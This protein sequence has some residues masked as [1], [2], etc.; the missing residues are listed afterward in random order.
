MRLSLLSALLI[1]GLWP[2]AGPAIAQLRQA[3][4][5][6]HGPTTVRDARGVA[7][8]LRQPPARIVSLAPAVTEI[9]FAVGAGPNVVGVTTYCDYPPQARRIAKVGD[10]NV[11]TEKVL[12][13]KPDLIIGDVEANRKSIAALERLA[14][15]RG[16]IFVIA[17][18]DFRNIFAAVEAVA[19]ITGHR[20]EGA[21]A[22]GAMKS[23]LARVKARVERTKVRPRTVFIV[24][25]DPLWVAAAGTFVDDLITAA[26]GQNLGRHA[27]RGY[28]SFSLERL[29]AL[30]P[31]V[32]V[33][34][35]T[36]LAS[37]SR[38]AGWSSMNAVRLKRVYRLGYDAV[39]PGPRLAQAVEHL[40][41]L[42]HP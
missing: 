34:S 39:R 21:R 30:D 27:G 32:I 5:A 31:D 17:G 23:T 33:S 2:G 8:T 26:G 28:R 40:H 36:T 19:A 42:L 11:S 18:K 1:I 22:L 13:L 10:L 25:A 20:T 38:K 14:P 37:L 29:I 4:A 12:A 6:A 9:L 15:V 7:I 3:R 16:H 41:T 35:D 24:Q